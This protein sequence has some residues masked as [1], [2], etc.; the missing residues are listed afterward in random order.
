MPHQ[1]VAPAKRN[2]AR[3]MHREPTEAEDRL[4]Q[5]LRGRRLDNIKV[6]R[7]VPMGRYVA[8]F[9]CAEARL[10]VEID[11]SQH[12]ESR[13]DQERDA[14]LKARGFRV[15]RFWNDDVLKELDAVCDTIIAYVRDESLQPW[16]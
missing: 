1:P 11:G 13:H 16:R 12:A 7:Q 5:E 14:E 15:L 6:R 2:F 4:W 3:A 8:D 10:I 9:V